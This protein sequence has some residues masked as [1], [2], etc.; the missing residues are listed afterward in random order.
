MLLLLVPVM[1]LLPPNDTKL[2]IPVTQNVQDKPWRVESPR[3]KT[4]QTFASISCS[5]T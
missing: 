3:H 1:N 4:S 2:L 5:E